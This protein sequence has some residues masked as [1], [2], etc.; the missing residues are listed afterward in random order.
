M[1][2]AFGNLLDGEP[3]PVV[4]QPRGLLVDICCAVWD[5]RYYTRLPF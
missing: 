1:A 3:G 2:A 5:P 4:D